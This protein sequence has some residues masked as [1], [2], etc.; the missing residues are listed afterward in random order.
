[1]AVAADADADPMYNFFLLKVTPEGVEELDSNYMDDY[2]FTAMRGQQVLKGNFYLRDN[3]HDMTFIL[4]KECTVA[5]YA[6]TVCHICGE[7]QVKKKGKKTIIAS[8]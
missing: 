1:M 2:N 3:I 6:A 5:V 7:L 8:L 4:D